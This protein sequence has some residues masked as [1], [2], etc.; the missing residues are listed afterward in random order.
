M[1]LTFQFLP[2]IFEVVFVESIDEVKGVIFFRKV[3]LKRK[4]LSVTKKQ[5]KPRDLIKMRKSDIGQLMLERVEESDSRLLILHFH[6][7]Q[8]CSKQKALE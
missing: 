2:S 3:N 4:G 6:W 7:S 8:V 1:C 5:K